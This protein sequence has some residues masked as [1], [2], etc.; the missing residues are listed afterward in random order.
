MLTGGTDILPIEDDGVGLLKIGDLGIDQRPEIT[1]VGIAAGGVAGPAGDRPAVVK[2]GKE[3]IPAGHVV[4]QTAGTPQIQDLF[5]PEGR[6]KVGQGRDGGGIRGKSPS[7]AIDLLPGAQAV[8]DLPLG[9]E[10]ELRADETGIAP[11]LRQAMK[12]ILAAFGFNTHPAEI[13]TIFTAKKVRH[14]DNLNQPLV[15]Y[16][17]SSENGDNGQIRTFP[18]GSRVKA[19]KYNNYILSII[20]T[21]RPGP[22]LKPKLDFTYCCG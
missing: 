21:S 19:L 6:E 17:V 9:K 16:Y 20:H 22:K 13:G 2:G 14:D 7:D 11:L 15:F 5:I 4:G 10:L 8:I 3:Q 18:R 12:G 1:F